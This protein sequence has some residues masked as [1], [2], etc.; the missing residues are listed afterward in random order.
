MTYPE[1]KTIVTLI[2]TTLVTICY[3]I[4]VFQVYTKGNPDAM[5]DLSFWGKAVLVL[6]PVQIVFTILVQ[7]FFAIVHKI[8]T[9]EDMPSLTD[10]RDKLIE[11]IAQRNSYFAF[12]AGFLLAMAALAIDKGPFVMFVVL[13]SAGIFAGVVEGITKLYLYNKGF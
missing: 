7:I 13:I 1:K 10:E 5:N 3:Y 6:I 2:S 11:L 4:Y 9:N 8:T 12:M